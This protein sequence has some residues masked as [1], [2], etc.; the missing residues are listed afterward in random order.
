L[1]DRQIF[2]TKE[3]KKRNKWPKAA[4]Q[5]YNW[6]HGETSHLISFLSFY[7]ETTLIYVWWCN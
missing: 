5:G 1:M 7:K 3:V 4:F 6:K 2:K